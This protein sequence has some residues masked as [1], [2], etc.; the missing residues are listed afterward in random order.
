[1]TGI[2]VLFGDH[3][4]HDVFPAH[5]VCQQLYT[6]LH[7][8]LTLQSDCGPSSGQAERVSTRGYS[9]VGRVVSN[10]S[11]DGAHRT[12]HYR[13]SDCPRYVAFPKF[14]QNAK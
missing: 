12:N 5:S 7:W 13:F 1:M 4:V 9:F 3:I 6:R 8:I 14:R 11:L 2:E 10:V